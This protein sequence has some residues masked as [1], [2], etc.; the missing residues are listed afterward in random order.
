M[1]LNSLSKSVSGI[2]KLL[3][4][5][6]MLYTSRPKNTGI[7]HNYPKMIISYLMILEYWRS[8]N[9]YTIDMMKGNM[10]C[11]DEELG[12]L[13]FSVLSRCVLGDNQRSDFEHMK[14]MYELLPVYMDVKQDIEADTK[15]Q[16]SIGWR[17]KVDIDSDE[18]RSTAFFF[19]RTIRLISQGRYLSYDGTP[20]CF[21][22]QTTANDH[23]TREY[24][25]L[26]Y[27]NDISGICDTLINKVRNE[28]NG[29]FLAR[30]TH[31][32]PE[33]EVTESEDDDNNGMEDD[34]KR[35]ICNLGT[36]GPDWELCKVGIFAIS[37]SEFTEEDGNIKKG[38]CVYKVLEK[39]T[40]TAIVSDPV[41]Y[42]FSGIEYICTKSNTNIACLSDGQ[43]NNS[44]L[45]NRSNI[46]DVYNYTIITYFDKLTTEKRLTS[47]IIDII[48]DLAT[49]ETIF[50]TQ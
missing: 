20:T 3:C 5:C 7:A 12:E 30:Y 38:I 26:V 19:K 24:L 17:H 39:N 28:L 48:S 8:I 18:V 11:V 45:W 14:K 46:E 23:L 33:T 25:P 44:S 27:M 16:Q 22:N 36:W 41:E 47:E 49:R 35:H 31:I 32:W 37:R 6:V 29:N 13:S 50:T 4:V 2:Y 9:H 1:R 10:S 43:W 34:E 40:D 21:N 42:A 15:N